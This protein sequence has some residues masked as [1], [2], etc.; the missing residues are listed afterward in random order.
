MLA[1]ELDSLRSV[2]PSPRTPIARRTN[3]NPAQ[4]N[5]S[6]NSFAASMNS[7]AV[8]LLISNP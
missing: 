6:S 8:S 1:H 7:H 4:C 5:S 2:R 3:P